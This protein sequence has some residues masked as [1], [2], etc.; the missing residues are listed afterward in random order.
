M[1][2]QGKSK[3]APKYIPPSSGK[4]LT[5][6]FD[7]DRK[8]YNNVF[9]FINGFMVTKYPDLSRQEI[10]SIRRDIVSKIKRSYTDNQVY[11]TI[12]SYYFTEGETAA[13]QPEGVVNTVFQ[14]DK[15]NNDRVQQI[16]RLIPKNTQGK[17]KTVLDIGCGDGAILAGLSQALNIEAEN[18]H[19]AD[20]IPLQNTPFTFHHIVQG[21]FG[22]DLHDG[23]VNLVTILM[24]LHHIQDIEVAIQEIHRVLAPGGMLI[25]RE[26]DCDVQKN[27]GL[28]MYLDIIHGLYMVSFSNPQETD[29]FSKQLTYYRSL[30]NWTDMLGSAGFKMLQTMGVHN[31]KPRGDKQVYYRVYT[32]A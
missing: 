1:Y 18:L 11:K 26:H 22:L 15:R 12:R 4:Q 20:I 13:A 21:K 7:I 27:P 5:G 30:Q 19:G 8:L 14:D 28:A 17:L 10:E 16:M 29:D 23:S 31:E 25:I 2:K 9:N 6:L 24:V 3:V 32:K